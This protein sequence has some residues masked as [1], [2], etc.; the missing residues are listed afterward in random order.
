MSLSSLDPPASLPVDGIGHVA[1]ADKRRHGLD[2]AKLAADFVHAVQLL[3]PHVN[4]V[5][6]GAEDHVHDKLGVVGFCGH[7]GGVLRQ[8]RIAQWVDRL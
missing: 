2:A 1:A 5:L 7:P 8:L 3:L 4:V 6:G